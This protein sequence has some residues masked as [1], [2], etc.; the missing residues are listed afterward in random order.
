MGSESFANRSI[1]RGQAVV[2]GGHLPAGSTTTY[3]GEPPAHT[4][5]QQRHVLSIQGMTCGGCSERVE[6]VLRQTQGVLKA[7]ISHETNDGVIITDSTLS[8]QQVVAVVQATG[9]QAKV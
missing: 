6:R 8:A 7:T 2:I 9:F 5:P 3:K 4:M 1:F